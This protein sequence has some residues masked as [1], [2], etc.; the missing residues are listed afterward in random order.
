MAAGTGSPDATSVPAGPNWQEQDA[1]LRDL[2]LQNKTPQEIGSALGRSVAAI[3]TR[4]ARL[5]LPR[6]SAPGRK[7][8]VPRP[9]RQTGQ[10]RAASGTRAASRKPVE[11][12]APPQISTRICLMCLRPFQSQGR[13][14][15][16]CPSCKESSEYASAVALAEINFPV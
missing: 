2:W 8:G 13:H 15:R 11:S 12:E 1:L 14:N 5:G 3:M 7:R 10:T 16:I 4:A 6:R 9:P